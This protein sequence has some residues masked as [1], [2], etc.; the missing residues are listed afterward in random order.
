MGRKQISC[1]E[2]D[3]LRAVLKPHSSCTNFVGGEVLNPEAAHFEVVMRASSQLSQSASRDLRLICQAYCRTLAAD[4][5]WNA[6][7]HTRNWVWWVLDL[8]TS[9]TWGMDKPDSRIDL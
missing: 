3:V 9:P 7:V 1:A 2:A 8:L 4:L 6:E 5:T